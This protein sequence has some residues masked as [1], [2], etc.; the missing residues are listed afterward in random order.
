MKNSRTARRPE[1]TAAELLAARRLAV[2]GQ[3]EILKGALDRHT[4]KANRD[5]KNY[6]YAGD[7]ARVMESLNEAL[8]ALGV[9]A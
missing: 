6:G 8:A 3:I 7:L 9:T 4:T 1:P 2:L 5:P